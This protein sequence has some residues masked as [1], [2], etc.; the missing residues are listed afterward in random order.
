MFCTKCGKELPEGSLF[1]T[2]CGTPVSVAPADVQHE[3]DGVPPVQVEPGAPAPE[4]APEPVVPAPAPE[5]V[6]P[7]PEPAAPEPTPPAPEP[8][9]PAPEPASQ[10]PAPAPMPAPMAP[11]P[12]P[13][14][15]APT[16]PASE[17]VPPA[18]TPAPDFVSQP[19]AKRGIGKTVGIVAAI[20]AVLAVLGVGGFFVYTTFFGT[21][22]EDVIMED[23]E[24]QLAAYTDPTTGECD[25]LLSEAE[26]VFSGTAISYDT[27]LSTSDYES[28]IEGTSY[29]VDGVTVSEDGTSATATA[30]ISLTPLIDYMMQQEGLGG[31]TAETK[32]AQLT[33]T[34]ERDGSEWVADGQEMRAAI[35]AA[36]LPTDEELIASDTQTFFGNGDEDIRATFVA[37]LESGA[38]SDLE[39]LGLTA[40]EFVDVLLEGS[41]YE[42]GAVSVDGDYGSVE[43]TVT[44]KQYTD[45][46]VQWEQDFYDWADTVDPSSVTN[47]EQLYE[48]AGEMLLD[49]ARAA[50]PQ[51]TT[52][53]VTFTQDSDGVWWMD[54][55]SQYDLMAAYGLV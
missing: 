25:R 24:A 16:A 31:A 37:A 8:M 51:T 42:I 1:C 47:E 39:L 50:E 9:P 14:P 15:P 12:A 4:P 32:E 40:D 7:A 30:T 20:V 27:S 3:E 52:V 45:I 5:P 48:Q 19:K 17:Q 23:L 13:T 33:V 43:V 6:T 11:A 53:T 49:A 41:S 29:T 18:P 21:S 22:A 34:Y 46:F 55:A 44:I 10:P 26:D 35:F 38:G 36:Y 54:E 28:W 2:A